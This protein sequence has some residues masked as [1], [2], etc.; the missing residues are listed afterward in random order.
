MKRKTFSSLFML[1]FFCVHCCADSYFV[2]VN[3]K[4]VAHGIGEKWQH[5]FPRGWNF[6]FFLLSSSLS[7]HSFLVRFSSKNSKRK[8]NY[9][10]KKRFFWLFFSSWKIHGWKRNIHSFLRRVSNS[11]RTLNW[12]QKEETFF[13][14][15]NRFQNRKKFDFD[16]KLFLLLILQSWG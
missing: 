2:W 7:W 4:F 16:I 11:Q 12:W 15:W 5:K 13:K 14:S 8:F 3:V 1:F 10:E 6:I 9:E